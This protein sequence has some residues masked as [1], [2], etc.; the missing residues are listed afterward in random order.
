MQSATLMTLISCELG[1]PSRLAYGARTGEE[2]GSN[3][4]VVRRENMHTWVEIHLPGLSWYPFDPTPALGV[5]IMEANAPGPV[6]SSG[7]ASPGALM[8]PDVEQGAWRP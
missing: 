4:C 8:P 3:E 5:P 6:D 1:V 7:T 2:V